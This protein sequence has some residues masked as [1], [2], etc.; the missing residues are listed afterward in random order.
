MTNAL[1]KKPGFSRRLEESNAVIFYLM[2]SLNLIHPPEAY[3]MR[4]LLLTTLCFYPLLA[5]AAH[6]GVLENAN[7]NG[8]KG[9]AWDSAHPNAHVKVDIYNGSIK[10]ATIAAK[11]FRQDL[12]DAGKGNGEHGFVYDFGA[13]LK[14]G[15]THQLRVKFTATA[16]PLSGSPKTTAVCVGALNDTGW[17][18]CGDIDD[19]DSNCP[20]GGFKGQDGDYGRDAKARA[21]T[22]KKKGGGA[23][24]FDFT[25]IANNGAKLPS[26]AVLGSGPN[27][28]AC[29]L[30]NATGLLWEV[31]TG[32][33]GLR[34]K[35]HTYSWYNPD[36]NSNGDYAGNQDGGTCGGSISCDTQGY[37]Q[38]VNAQGLCGRKDWRMPKQEELRSLVSYDRV[39]PSI[40]GD[41]FP[42]TLPGVFWSAS[43]YNSNIGLAWVVS[44]SNGDGDDGIDFD[45]KDYSNA[46]RLVRGGQ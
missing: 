5:Q 4:K 19:N 43:P 46:V 37:V 40:D 42:N 2:K 44:F 31:K 14:N 32:D 12:L 28:W 25:K 35:D 13:E 23:A 15:K 10:V 33:G 20:V 11:Q 8:V 3:R 41:Y 38:A 7:C 26:T 30:D 34:D 18:T 36:P 9:W 6:E 29:T 27:D 17:Q 16:T 1:Y 24:G 21:G 22:L 45:I 39:D